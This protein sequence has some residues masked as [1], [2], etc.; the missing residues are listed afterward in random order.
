M[1]SPVNNNLTGLVFESHNDKIELDQSL[2]KLSSGNKLIRAG[3]D[4]GAFSQAS[5]LG[6]KNKRDLVSLQNLQNLVS[7]SQSQDGALEKAGGILDRM[8]EITVRALDVTAT[9]ADRENYNKEFL[10]LSDLLEQMSDEKFGG[11]NLFGEGAFSQDKKDFIDALQKQWL[12][13]A[14][15]VIEERFGLSPEG[16][17][18][19]D[20]IVNENDT[21][22]YT[23]FVA[24]AGQDVIEMQFDLPDFQSPFTA[25]S[26]DS[27]I[28]RADRVVAHEMTHAVMADVLNLS[29]SVDGTASGGSANWFI[30]GTA[31]FIHGADYRVVADLGGVINLDANQSSGNDIAFNDAAAQQAKV[32]ANGSS[33]INAIGNGTEGWS[34]S[35]QYSAGYI[36]T[37]YLHKELKDNGTGATDGIKDMLIWMKTNNESVGGALK[38]FLGSHDPAKYGTVTNK[39]AHD[40]FINDFKTNGELFLRNTMDLTNTDTGAING[41]DADSKSIIT[42]AEAVPN[43]GIGYAADATAQT[44]PLAT[45][46]GGNAGFTLG[47]E[48]DDSALSAT[49][50]G[51]GATYD[52]KSIYSVQVSDTETF[53]LKSISSARATLNELSTLMIN[54]STE[55]ANVGANLSRLDKEIQNL[56]GKIMTGEM[57]VGRIQDTD[58]A[59]ESTKFAS[60]QVRMQASIAI[61]AQAKDLNV[62]I[63]DLIRGIMIGQ[64]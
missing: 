38:H 17:D 62:G 44:Q 4:T 56:N 58:I 32:D 61:L 57:A 5:K 51:T 20:I 33:I 11:L 39:Q 48:E 12:K 53:N 50:D 46:K 19:F 18:N 21:G 37:R 30:E 2:A 25:P 36:A 52:L 23:A 9:D 45:T 64:P 35:P 49:V 28:Y 3:D 26:S 10:E 41:L 24:F 27:P 7:Y 42:A 29:T 59:T 34:A 13:G 1:I 22:G 15:N 47:W 55:R 8:N 54:L 14:M 60:S 43:S 63:R 40:N 6:S 31:E 16:T